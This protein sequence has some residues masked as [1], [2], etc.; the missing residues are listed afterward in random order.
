M[1]FSVIF[2]SALRVLMRST[3]K[4][5]AISAYPQRLCGKN[6][7][8]SLGVM[9][10]HRN[11]AVNLHCLCV[12]A[13]LRLCVK[14]FVFAFSAASSLT[15]AMQLHKWHSGGF[16][17]AIRCTHAISVASAEPPADTKCQFSGF[18]RASRQ[19]FQRINCNL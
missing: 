1:P 5:S 14:F 2:V 4:H 10:F 16:T 15:S 18:S 11:L 9:L 8:S 7:F 17:G 6:A 19:T 12:F 3:K 13:T